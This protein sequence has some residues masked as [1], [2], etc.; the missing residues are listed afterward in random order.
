MIRLELKMKRETFRG[1]THVYEVYEDGE[2]RGTVQSDFY[3]SSTTYKCTRIR[4]D[5]GFPKRW[6]YTRA[7]E[8]SNSRMKH[9]TRKRAVDALLGRGWS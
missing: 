1:V 6:T 4:H 5:Y 8:F 7:G 9:D 2:L 3:R